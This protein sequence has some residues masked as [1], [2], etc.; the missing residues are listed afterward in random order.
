MLENAPQG[1]HG[2]DARQLAAQAARQ[3][4]DRAPAPAPA[5]P[6]EN[7]DINKPQ[8]ARSLMGTLDLSHILPCKV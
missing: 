4:Y 1:H 3:R 8:V 2:Q 6:T 7:A 5:Q